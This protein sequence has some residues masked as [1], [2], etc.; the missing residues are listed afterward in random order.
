MHIWKTQ[1]VYNGPAP[2][3]TMAG[4]PSWWERPDPSWLE[5][6]ERDSLPPG[7]GPKTSADGWFVSKRANYHL[8]KRLLKEL[9]LLPQPLQASVPIV[10]RPEKDSNCQ[11]YFQKTRPSPTCREQERYDQALQ[12]PAPAWKMNSLFLLAQVQVLSLEEDRQKT[13]GTQHAARLLAGHRVLLS[14]RAE[15]PLSTKPLGGQGHRASPTLRLLYSPFSWQWRGRVWVCKC[16]GLSSML[17]VALGLL[18]Q[19]F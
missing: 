19:D 11:A 6:S 12:E 2:L 10:Q 5:Q 8:Q 7:A 3:E 18:Q 4:I 9:L 17:S 13:Y 15:E 16:P 14:N 1:K